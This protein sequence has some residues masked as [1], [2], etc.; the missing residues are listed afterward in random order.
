MLIRLL[1]KHSP[2][3]LSTMKRLM[4]I[5]VLFIIAGIIHGQTTESA[6]VDMEAEIASL[7]ELMDKIDL[8]FENED[9][10]FFTSSLAEDALI[11]GTDPSE[12][13]SKKEF[14]EMNES[15]PNT[16][17]PEFNYMD[18]RVIMVAPDGNSAIVVTQYIIIWSPNI[19]WRQ[20][21]HF[22][23]TGDGWKAYFVNIAFIPKNEHIGI[24]NQAIE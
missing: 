19:P 5:T 16:P 13:W 1:F 14:L 8:G 18:D 3:K 22:I 6:P 21:Y 15:E 4:L 2:I 24:I 17:F 7:N 9:G 23:K 11:C 20:V 12:F 10:S